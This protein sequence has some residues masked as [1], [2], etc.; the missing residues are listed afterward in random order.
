LLKSS[1]P[2]EQHRSVLIVFGGKSRKLCGG[3]TAATLKGPAGIIAG[4]SAADGDERQSRS[5]IL[6]VN[7]RKIEDSRTGPRTLS[8]AYRRANQNRVSVAASDASAIKTD[9]P[10]VSDIAAQ[11][12]IASAEVP[13]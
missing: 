7:I 12:Q 3:R 5:L 2:F 9:R 4:V 10:V 13:H 6:E 1:L 8:R 11:S